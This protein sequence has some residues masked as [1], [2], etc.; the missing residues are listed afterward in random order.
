MEHLYCDAEV[1][2]R[3]V[4]PREGRVIFF[5]SYMF[6]RTKP[7]VSNGQRISLAFDFIGADDE[8]PQ[9]SWPVS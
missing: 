1:P 8:P 9:F 7:F 4:E 6:H 3:S 5:P 2:V